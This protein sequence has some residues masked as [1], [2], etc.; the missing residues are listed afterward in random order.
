MEMTA[1]E[2]AI[3]AI[4][5]QCLNHLELRFPKFGNTFIY[6]IQKLIMI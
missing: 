4:K 5:S 6:I 2:P 1:L 3:F